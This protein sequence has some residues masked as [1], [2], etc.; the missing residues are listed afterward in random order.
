MREPLRM[1]CS[2]S[3][4][5]KRFNH[6]QLDENGRECLGF[7][8]DASKRMTTML[9]DLLQYA[10]VGMT[11]KAKESVC[12]NNVLS[13]VQ[14]NLGLRIRETNAEIKI[15]TLPCIEGHQ[16][17]F[18]QIFQNLIANSLK[19]SKKNEAPKIE[20]IYKEMPKEHIFAVRDNGIG[21]EQSDANGIF[22][23][24]RRLHSRKEYEG[25]GLGLA[26]C[27]ELIETMNGRIWVTSELGVGSVFYI[28]LPKEK[29][30]N[31]SYLTSPINGSKSILSTS[32][33]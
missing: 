3:Q 16:T 26:T 32:K 1:I 20:I 25:S 4:V 14:N 24:F 19:F 7:I 23:A 12:L 8:E 21:M 22:K 27:S 6:D 5:L 30:V 9:D 33:L 15:A 29:S 28:S 31:Q 11:E 13:M 10:R 17:F 18:L 2:F